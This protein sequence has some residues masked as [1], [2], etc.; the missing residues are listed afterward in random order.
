LRLDQ[1]DLQPHCSIHVRGKGARERILP[2]WKETAIALRSWRAVRGAWPEPELFLNARH[3]SM[4]RSGFKYILSKH[5]HTATAKQPSLAK[6]RVS[7]H[8]L[9]HYVPSPTMSRDGG[10]D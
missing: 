10:S 5:V 2:L 8:V 7:P 9:R 1:L 6:K 3:G 4:T